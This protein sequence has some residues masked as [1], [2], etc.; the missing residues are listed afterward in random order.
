[1]PLTSAGNGFGLVADAGELRD[2]IDAKLLTPEEARKIYWA[3]FPGL[4][5]EAARTPPPIGEE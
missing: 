5:Q 2:A 1:M 4:G 3:Q